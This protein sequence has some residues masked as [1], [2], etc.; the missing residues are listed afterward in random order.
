[1]AQA[2]ATPTFRP[3]QLVSYKGHNYECR[4]VGQTKYGLRAKLMFRDGSKEFW[5]DAEALS[6]PTTTVRTRSYVCEECGDHVS[7]GS[8]CWE[9]GL[10]H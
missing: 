10:T 5:A 9:T 1:M 4:W 8:S 2:T 6:Y 7:P 3:G